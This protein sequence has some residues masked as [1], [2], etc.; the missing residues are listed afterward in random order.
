MTGGGGQQNDS[1]GVRF[2]PPLLYALPWLAGWL[3]GRLVPVRWLP[4]I[5]AVRLVGWPLVAAAV[6]LTGTAV[7][8]FRALGN[9]P[10]PRKPVVALAVEGPYRWTRNPMYL[11]LAALYI[12]L[13]ALF[14]TVWPLVFLPF[15]ILLIQRLVIA[16]EERYLEAK[17][18]QTFRD[19]KARVRRW[20]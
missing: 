13:A 4:S 11:G 16:K 1:S 9:T 5:T 10:N 8:L 20:I 18:G 2:P 15:V 12:G 19:Y 17:F 6:L 3:L 14:N 7:G